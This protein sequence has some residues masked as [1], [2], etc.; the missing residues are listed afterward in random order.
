MVPVPPLL[1]DTG[2]AGSAAAR[3]PSAAARS[4]SA[5][6]RAYAQPRPQS[7]APRKPGARARS[8]RLHAGM[9]P[10]C[11][12]NGSGFEPNGSANSP[13]KS[14]ELSAYLSAGP[15]TVAYQYEAYPLESAYEESKSRLEATLSTALSR[16][17]AVRDGTLNLDD[18]APPVAASQKMAQDYMGSVRLHR[19]RQQMLTQ[20]YGGRNLCFN[21]DGERSAAEVR[22]N[23]AEL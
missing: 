3:S 8:A 9:P 13:L 14:A 4:P 12:P 10:D 20:F 18:R 11:Y 7:S 5:V 17:Q 15:S 16:A 21:P 19:R 23:L 1:A 6:Q 2:H 22:K